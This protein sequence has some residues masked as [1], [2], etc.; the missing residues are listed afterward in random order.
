[1]KR[2]KNSMELH[3]HKH[4]STDT[5]STDMCDRVDNDASNEGC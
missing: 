1:M 2:R 3:L 4:F 5:G